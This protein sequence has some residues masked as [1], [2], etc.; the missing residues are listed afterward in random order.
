MDVLWEGRPDNGKDSRTPL[1]ER[2][3]QIVN[4]D[5]LKS[6]KQTDQ[7]SIETVQNSLENINLETEREYQSIDKNVLGQVYELYCFRGGGFGFRKPGMTVEGFRALVVDSLLYGK[8]TIRA[9]RE[10]EL[11]TS[12]ILS[13]S[14]TCID[15]DRFLTALQ[16]LA[17]RV[18]WSKVE[19]IFGTLNGV[20]SDGKLLVVLS[21][22]IQDSPR[23]KPSFIG[24][25]KESVPAYVSTSQERIHRNYL[26]QEVIASRQLQSLFEKNQRGFQV[27]YKHYLRRDACLSG[28]EHKVSGK[29]H[30]SINDMRRFTHDFGIFP[31]YIS[32]ES[33]RETILDTVA[34]SE[35]HGK[36]TSDKNSVEL[37][38]IAEFV[39]C[40][41]MIAYY[42]FGKET[43]SAMVKITSLEP[44]VVVSRVI[45]L[46]Q[47]MNYMK[48]KRPCPPM[49]VDYVRFKDNDNQTPIGKTPPRNRKYSVTGSPLSLTE[50]RNKSFSSPQTKGSPLK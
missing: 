1:Q 47:L 6:D 25:L 10:A 18:N 37:H 33:L 20:T 16:M 30:L 24:S 45:L 15:F 17:K 2:N 8:D 7:Y 38:N 5:I 4:N 27:L 29:S 46:F 21:R 9:R 41:V 23:K 31:D 14:A 11:I 39:R 44:S 43:F 36:G 32:M 3:E 19:H 26:F 22:L 34:G 50:R 35:N 40:T 13:K 42:S 49:P 48:E 28:N 12:S